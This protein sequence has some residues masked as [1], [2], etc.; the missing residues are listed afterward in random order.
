MKSDLQ[1]RRLDETR[2]PDENIPRFAALRTLARDRERLS[3]GGRGE[4]HA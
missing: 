2:R 1:T 4:G 3:G